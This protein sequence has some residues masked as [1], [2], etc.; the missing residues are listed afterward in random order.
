MAVAPINKVK[1][2][3]DY[4]ITQIPPEK[5]FMGMPNYGYNWPLPFLRGETI[6]KSLGNVEAVNL[7]LKYGA[8]IL[9]D[10]IAQAPY[11]YYTDENGV[12]HVVW[13]EDAR[14]IYT[15]LTTAFSYGFPGVSYWNLMRPFPQNWLVASQLFNIYKV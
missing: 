9:F 2:V 1:A 8:E 12:E 15:K 13:F 7:A 6:A 3:L 11:F 5:I 10:E 4:A 14:S